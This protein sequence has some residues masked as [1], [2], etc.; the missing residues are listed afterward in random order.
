MSSPDGMSGHTVQVGSL[1]VVTG[2]PGAGKSTVARRVV[3]HLEPSVLVEGDAFFRFLAGGT[4]EPWRPESH[5]QNIVVTEAAAMAT[6]HFVAVGYA[7]V[8]DG[9][10]GAWFLPTFVRSTGLVAID[11]VVILPTVEL[12]VER[13]R[14]RIGHG[15][16]DEEATG[17]MHHEFV[18][19]EI[20]ERYVL[21]D[22][23]AGADELAKRILEAQRR[24]QLQYRLDG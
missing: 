15:F 11:Y 4:I 13:V 16:T 19:A 21:S 14:S 7:T 2:P 20:D 5:A 24:G 3:E 1:L 18:V 9:V 10:I 8:Y 23:L 17:K 12:C 6:G 22:S